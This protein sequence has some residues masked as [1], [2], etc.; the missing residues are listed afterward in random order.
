MRRIVSLITVVALVV[1][2]MLA[3]SVSA[4]AK[5]VILRQHPHPRQHLHLHL[6]LHLYLHRRLNPSIPAKR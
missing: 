5:N 6:H 2:V 4:G 3:S 1:A